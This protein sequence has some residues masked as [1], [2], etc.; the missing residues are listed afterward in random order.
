MFSTLKA[1]SYE[2]AEREFHNR[3]KKNKR[4]KKDNICMY[5]V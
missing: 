4:T 2:Y 1:A 3:G 5:K